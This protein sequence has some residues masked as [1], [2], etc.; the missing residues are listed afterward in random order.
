MALF[1]SKFISTCLIFISCILLYWVNIIHC[2]ILSEIKK[3]NTPFTNETIN[4]FIELVRQNH[5]YDMI[6]VNSYPSPVNYP[7]IRSWKR[8]IQIIYSD[9]IQSGH[10]ICVY[11]DP[12]YRTAYIYD[13][14]I[15]NMNYIISEQHD[16]IVKNRYPAAIN[17]T[18]VVSPKT[19]QY[20]ET[21]SGPLVIAYATTLILGET[22][23]NYGFQMN[24]ENQDK[25]IHLRE[26]IFEMLQNRR[27]SPFPRSPRLNIEY[28]ADSFDNIHPDIL[29]KI[30]TPNQPFDV[31]TLMLF[32]R[33]VQAT[34]D[35]DMVSTFFF[36]YPELIP[37][38][39]S[40]KNDV[41]ILYAKQDQ[42]TA[43]AVC[44]FYEAA[45]Q[46]VY[47]YDDEDINI[48][49][50]KSDFIER[51]YPN[52]KN[53]TFVEPKTGQMDFVSCG[54]YSIAYATT[55]ILGHDPKT[56]KLR[57]RSLLSSLCGSSMFDDPKMLRKHILK[58]FKSKKLLPFP[59]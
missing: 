18:V 43:H 36:S 10:Y 39:N 4:Y 53:I 27:L 51:R 58:M 13:S 45:N 19:E 17:R 34:T 30:T 40:T 7:P 32:N 50:A 28:I 25:A 11:Y 23:A 33:L 29:Q 57:T 44:I 15:E 31:R 8:D 47:V 26:H 48:T 14:R 22:P 49:S 9:A 2:D 1:Y 5:G 6:D 12:D 42:W 20:D 3:P 21:S 24:V 41:Q 59:K 37:V 52:L 46:M 16:L 35:F 56:Y 38:H 55:L 54:A